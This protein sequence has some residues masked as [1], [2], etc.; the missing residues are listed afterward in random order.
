MYDH[1]GL[2]VR[3]LG[4]SVRFFEAALAAG[5]SNNGPLCHAKEG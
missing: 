4:A 3:D 5:D 1:I 2:R